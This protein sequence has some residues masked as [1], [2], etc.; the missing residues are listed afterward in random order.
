M[1]ALSWRAVTLILANHMIAC[2]TWK[3]DPPQVNT[4][5]SVIRWVLMV[6][7]RR[8]PRAL[9]TIFDYK[10][11]SKLWEEGEKEK[12]ITTRVSWWPSLQNITLLILQCVCGKVV[13]WVEVNTSFFKSSFLNVCQWKRDPYNPTVIFSSL[14]GM[15]GNCLLYLVCSSYSQGV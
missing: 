7:R 11:F 9:S 4:N 14:M 6:L 12:E 2:V 1:L 3:H 13:W 8:F 10:G 15:M 5:D